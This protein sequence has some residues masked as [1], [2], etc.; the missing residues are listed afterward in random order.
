MHT[1]HKYT[2]LCSMNIHLQQMYEALL[3]SCP[4]ITQVHTIYAHVY[5]LLGTYAD[6]CSHR[7]CI[8]MY[9]PDTCDSYMFPFLLDHVTKGWEDT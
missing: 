5:A 9:I 7:I 4:H 2:Y 6:T 3:H 8:Y 1:S